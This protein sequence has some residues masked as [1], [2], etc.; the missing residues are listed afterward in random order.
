MFTSTFGGDEVI[1]IVERDVEFEPQPTEIKLLATSKTGTM[2]EELQEAGAAGFEFVGLT[3]ASTTFGGN[4]LVS[5]M[6]R[7]PGQ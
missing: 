1:L 5:I 7:R 4:E 2:Q 3:V 6:A